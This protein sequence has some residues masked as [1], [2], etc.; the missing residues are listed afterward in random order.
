SRKLASQITMKYRH[1][2]S[3]LELVQACLLVTSVYSSRLYPRALT[4]D[5]NDGTL[6]SKNNAAFT[7]SPV[8]KE[9]PRDQVGENEPLALIKTVKQEPPDPTG[10][11][12]QAPPN[13]NFLRAKDEPKLLAGMSFSGQRD[14]QDR[15]PGPVNPLVP[16]KEEPMETDIV[17]QDYNQHFYPISPQPQFD[18]KPLQ[19]QIYTQT[20]KSFDLNAQAPPDSQETVPRLFEGL[21]I[22]SQGKRRFFQGGREVFLEKPPKKLKL[23]ITEDKGK[24]PLFD[25]PTTPRQSSRKLGRVAKNA[26]LNRSED[27]QLDPA[28]LRLV[29]SWGPTTPEQAFARLMADAVYYAHS[30]ELSRIKTDLPMHILNCKIFEETP[31]L[32]KL[33]QI[34]NALLDEMANSPLLGEKWRQQFEALEKKV[35]RYDVGRLQGEGLKQIQ[36][37][38][39]KPKFIN[40]AYAPTFC[41][42]DA[43]LD[44]QEIENIFNTVDSGHKIDIQESIPR[45]PTETQRPISTS[46]GAGPSTGRD[47]RPPEKTTMVGRT[48]EVQREQLDE[49]M[50]EAMDFQKAK[51]QKIDETSIR[52]VASDSIILDGRLFTRIKS[53]FE[54]TDHPELQFPSYFGEIANVIIDIYQDS[55]KLKEMVPLTESFSNREHAFRRVLVN[56]TYFM[57]PIFLLDGFG[58]ALFNGVTVCLIDGRRAP[59]FPYKGLV[60]E[61]LKVMKRLFVDP[62]VGVL[63]RLNVFK[64]GSPAILARIVLIQRTEPKGTKQIEAH[65]SAAR[66]KMKLMRAELEKM[67]K[68][69]RQPSRPSEKDKS[70]NNAYV[71]NIRPR[72]DGP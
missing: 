60:I 27:K 8:V 23:E 52:K 51:K 34:R 69:R 40:E 59:N 29:N 48:K 49:T 15:N 2:C 25:Q 46:D 58:E 11:H 62:N 1:P 63:N 45:Q 37:V 55:E 36:S 71:A 28:Q 68:A 26:N 57:K 66:K 21:Y 33:D 13:F 47:T 64:A 5:V 38:L 9:E 31:L 70:I 41:R 4:R 44:I 22:T 32:R 50:D 35:P 14:P 67:Q 16:V 42:A 65:A 56:L 53:A 7:L 17:E 12:F 6:L 18:H 54:V 72:I 24:K 19:P 39:L 20:P 30:E 3:F 61:H 43:S 10:A